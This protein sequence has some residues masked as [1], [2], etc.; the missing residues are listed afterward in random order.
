MPIRV[1]IA[2]RPA[3]GLRAGTGRCSST[4]LGFI[5]RIQINTIQLSHEADRRIE[6]ENT[7]SGKG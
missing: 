4:Y 6:V 7:L 5:P 1:A 2:I 3:E